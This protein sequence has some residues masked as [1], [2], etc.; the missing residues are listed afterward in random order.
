PEAKEAFGLREAARPGVLHHGW[1]AAGQVADRTVAGPAV[2]ELGAVRLD[3]TE[4]PPR[5]LDVGAV[6]FG[7][8]AHIPRLADPPPQG[9][10]ARLP[11]VEVLAEAHGQLE[12]R[13]GPGLEIRVFEERGP[14]VV[15]E[16]HSLELE[17][18]SPPVRDR[19][20]GREALGSDERPRGKGDGRRRVV[21]AQ[22]A[23]GEPG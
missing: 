18:S 20:V 2:D 13:G 12:L 4:L 16:R 17:R 3:T 14:L 6:L 22:A 21:P 15:G 10:E 8:P 5:S 1:L 19:R 7:C 9:F 23:V 11:L